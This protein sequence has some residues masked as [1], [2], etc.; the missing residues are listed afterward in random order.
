MNRHFEQIRRLGFFFWIRAVGSQKL[1]KFFGLV[2]SVRFSGSPFR[3]TASGWISLSRDKDSQIAVQADCCFH[4]SV[5]LTAVRYAFT[6]PPAKISIGENCQIKKGVQICCKSGTIRFGSRCALG[7]RSELNCWRSSILIGNDVRIAAEVY[8]NTVS[9]AHDRVD[10]P[11]VEQGFEFEDIVIEDDVWIGR[12]AIILPGVRIGR[13][14]IVAAGAIV[15]KNTPPYSIVA[16]VP[17][18][19]K[20]IRGEVAAENT[21]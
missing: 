8:L 16:G 12:R 3:L 13:G 9:H 2:Q 7:H 18:V 6:E 17:A 4:Q 10:I 11:V 19:I 20:K 14:T 5:S 1:C 21:P 15:T